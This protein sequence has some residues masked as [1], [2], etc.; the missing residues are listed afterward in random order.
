MGLTLGG[1]GVD[2]QASTWEVRVVFTDT[3][4]LGLTGFCFLEASGDPLRNEIVREDLRRGIAG[5]MVR[6]LTRTPP[7]RPQEKT[8]LVAGE[9]TTS[10]FRLFRRGGGLMK[11]ASADQSAVWT[12]GP[13]P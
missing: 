2:G 7:L 5:L 8:T 13:L 3:E 12:G 11:G 6:F 10:S 1:L 4:Q 9:G